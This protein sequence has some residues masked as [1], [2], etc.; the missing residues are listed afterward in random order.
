MIPMPWCTTPRPQSNVPVVVLDVETTGLAA[1]DR[2]VEIATLDPD[3]LEIVEEY[4]T[5]VNP[6]RDISGA[7]S[8]IHGLTASNLEAAPTFQDIVPANRHASQW[9]RPCRPQRPL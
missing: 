7:V 1:T 5:L 2:I 8:D 4:D 3:T 6:L 9:R